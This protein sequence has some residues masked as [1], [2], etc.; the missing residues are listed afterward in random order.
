MAGDSRISIVM[1]THNRRPEALRSLGILAALPEQPEVIVVDNGSSDDTIAAIGEHFPKVRVVAAGQNL[2]AAGRNLGVAAATTPYVALCDDDTWWQPEALRQAANLFDHY[3]RLALITARV[4]VGPEEIEDPT[5]R[6]MAQSPLRRERDM[7]GPALLGFLAGASAL[8]RD[9]FLAAG[10]FTR[11]AFIGGEEAWLAAELAA[12]QWWLCYVEELVVHHHPSP[13]RD[14][15]ARRAQEIRNALWFAW[16]R[17]PWRSALKRTGKLALSAARGWSSARAFV[18][19]C[20]ALPRLWRD[21]Q[22]V[23]PFVEEGFCRL[24]AFTLTPSPPQA[25]G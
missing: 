4:L 21:R 20:A 18:G 24:D 9:A 5:C 7:P 3:P 19:A 23:P 14:A 22:V 6:I 8:R 15:K 12:R 11:R 16:L 25:A 2:G 10:G 13:S 17:R 1:I